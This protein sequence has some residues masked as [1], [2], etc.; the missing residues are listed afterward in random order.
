MKKQLFLISFFLIGFT[1]VFSQ[2]KRID[3]PDFISTS[4]SSIEAEDLVISLTAGDNIINF[5]QIEDALALTPEYR[6]GVIEVAISDLKIFFINSY[7][8]LKLFVQDQVKM[9]LA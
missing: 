6:P 7:L 1:C 4:G 5:L 9:L 8:C 3:A 2:S